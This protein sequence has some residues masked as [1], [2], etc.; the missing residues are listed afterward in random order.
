MVLCWE[1]H[2]LTHILTA[3][4]LASRWRA[5]EHFAEDGAW[6]REAIAR[7]TLRLL[8][9]ERPARWGRY[10]PVAGDDTT[11]HC[12]SKT[13]WGTC[14]FHDARARSPQRAETVRAHNW[15]VMGPLLPG[16]PWTY[17]GLA[18]RVSCRQA[19]WP[20]G[21]P[22]RTKTALAVELW[23]Q[24]DAASRA[25]LLAVLDGADA[26]DTVVRPCLEP[27]PGPRRLAVVT[28][29]RAEARLYHPVGA[30][31]HAQGRP[32][33]WGPR[34][35]APQ[36]QVSWPVS[37]QASPAWVYGRPRHFP[38]TQ[39][40]CRGAVS[41]PQ[42]PGH[43][44]VIHMAGDAEPWFLSTSALDLSAA[45]V[46]EAWAARFRQGDGFRDHKPRLGSEAC[47]A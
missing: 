43:V 11:R 6:D 47:R 22:F 41:G 10:H 27:G 14:T 42:I 17:L 23:R 31:P 28:R 19:Q 15:V 25:P 35:A 37:W 36:P 21:D 33:A 38:Y 34:I 40:R 46:V 44:L 2:P 32:P 30:R 8:A 24:A 16:R 5:L 7:H 1:E 13:G 18:A 12:T 20:A 9:Q 3:V 29:L 39:F 45:H 4:G 26:M